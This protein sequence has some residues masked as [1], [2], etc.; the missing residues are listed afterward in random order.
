MSKFKYND[1]VEVTNDPENDGFFVGAKGRITRRKVTGEVEE[2]CVE[3]DGQL[4]WVEPDV[5]KLCL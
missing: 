5:I 3:V 4:F 2:Y 1:K